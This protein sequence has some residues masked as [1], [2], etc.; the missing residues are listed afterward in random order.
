M[1]ALLGSRIQ[2]ARDEETAMSRWA[3]NMTRETIRG[4]ES[5]RRAKE[6]DERRAAR[7][8]R[9][10]AAQQLVGMREA[11][12]W[13]HTG[14]VEEQVRFF[15][16]M[17]ADGDPQTVSALRASLIGEFEAMPFEMPDLLRAVPKKP[18]LGQF[19]GEVAR[20]SWL[21]SLF[22]SRQERYRS[23]LAIADASYR[24]SL[25]R[26]ESEVNE[27]GA[28][29]DEARRLHERKEAERREEHLRMQ[30]HLN[31]VAAAG[32]SGDRSALADLASAVLERNPWGEDCS[33]GWCCE[34]RAVLPDSTLHLELE[35]PD[36]A[37]VP[38]A[39]RY[40][41]V[42]KH[43]EIREVAR[44]QASSRALYKQ[45]VVS[46]LLSAVHRAFLIGERLPESLVCTGWRQGQNPSTGALERYCV[47]SVVAERS[48]WET[49]CVSECDP[50]ALFKD[51]KGRIKA[52]ANEYAPVTPHS[53]SNRT[54]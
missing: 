25:A 49:R 54:G 30:E 8:Q 48:D 6:A 31:Q 18:R 35:L 17:L 13:M 34:V 41:Y 14:M 10:A 9:R 7:E 5:L 24:S 15:T 46:M 1:A 28:A 3:Y 50:L 27:H 20:P 32:Q 51:L 4:I 16:S 36:P 26:Y 38:S 42:K 47:G 39:T 43:D 45:I 23:E 37:I 2:R 52:R 53:T 44:S 11:E 21:A 22:P 19:R 29:L 40:R 33:V 12:A